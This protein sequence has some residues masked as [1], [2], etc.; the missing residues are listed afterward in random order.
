MEKRN[1]IF[2]VGLLVAAG[3]LF[4]AIT[5]ALD[6]TVYMMSVDEVVDEGSRYVGEELK[7]VGHVEPGSIN[8]LGDDKVRFM[9]THAGESVDVVY[10]GPRPDAFKDCAD[11][12]LTGTLKSER[13]FEAYDMLAQC[14]S[15]Y[16]NVPKTCEE[17]LASR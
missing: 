8:I 6:D 17:T 16:E 11:L 13:S 10:T 12:V 2:V 14:P 7:M 1:I 4:W 15:R 5:S 3:L 9:L